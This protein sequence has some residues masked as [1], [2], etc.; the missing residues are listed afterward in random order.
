MSIRPRRNPETAPMS[1]P[2]T[3]LLDDRTRRLE[4]A[5]GRSLDPPRD[6]AP[7]EP[8]LEADK[9]RYLLE[10]A[11]EL[12]WNELEWEQLTSEEHL[13]EG[14]LTELTFPGFLAFIRGLLLE[15]TLP[16]AETDPTPRPEVVN[17]IL[18]FLADEADRLRRE[19]DQGAEDAE[20]EAA[21]EAALRLT[22]RLIDLVLIQL[23]DLTGEEEEK[24]AAV[25]DAG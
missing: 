4:E 7:G 12:Y 15:E 18:R 23:H 2:A 5:L 8:P 19:L 3:E 1:D 9:R 25:L 20:E 10:E 24:V 13:D 17:D 22:L 14:A 6:A 21:S 16:D 11:E